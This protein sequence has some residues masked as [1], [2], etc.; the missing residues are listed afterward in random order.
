MK[1]FD[2][3][4]LRN[5]NLGHRQQVSSRESKRKISREKSE[6][7]GYGAENVFD[8]VLSGLISNIQLFYRHDAKTCAGFINC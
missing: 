1:A 4:V 2:S 8:S 3:I 7:S 6:T 5:H